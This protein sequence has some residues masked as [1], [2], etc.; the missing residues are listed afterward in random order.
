MTPSENRWQRPGK[1]VDE[2]LQ[3]SRFY[4]GQLNKL[5]VEKFEIITKEI[6]TFEIKSPEILKELIS[7]I[8]DKATDEAHFSS[9]YAELC[10]RVQQITPN[11]ENNFTFRRA[12]LNKCQE[13]FEKKAEEDVS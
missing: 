13:E 8:F 4:R 7:L 10:A 6:V 3:A 12:L 5:T 1:E 9:M 11:F 2:V